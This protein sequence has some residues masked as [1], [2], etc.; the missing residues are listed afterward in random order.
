MSS[1]TQLHRLAELVKVKN[2]VEAEITA[3]IDRPAIIGHVGEYIA[4]NIFNI[5]LEESASNKGIDGYFR[6]G[7]LSGQSVNVKFYTK[8]ERLLDITPNF[9]PD[10]YLVLTGDMNNACSSRGMV[11]PWCISY[12]YLFESKSLIEKLQERKLKIGTATSVAKIFWETA[13]VYPN[14]KNN[15]LILTEEQKGL[16]K[17]F[18]I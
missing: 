4:S 9:L 8:N 7:S 3:I 18:Q 5:E 12:V 10:Y 2:S 15:S 11:K 1:L 16:I 6:S 13:E 14:S 17:L